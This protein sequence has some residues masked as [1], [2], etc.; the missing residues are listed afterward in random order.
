MFGRK[1]KESQEHT[2]SYP[3]VPAKEA[4]GKIAEYKE[5]IALG[6]E[7]IK[8]EMKAFEIAAENLKAASK[9]VSKVKGAFS[10][11]LSKRTAKKHGGDIDAYN[12]SLDAYI[13]ISS[14]I[15]WLLNTV[16]S[17]YEASA[18]L[19]EGMKRYSIARKLRIESKKYIADINCKKAKLEKVAD[20]IM[21]PLTSYVR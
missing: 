19:Y 14:H 3:S 17:C 13:R 8:T 16:S 5:S 9:K 10:S 18:R 6:K 1:S 4:K 2:R 7:S 12:E 20:G 15:N 11:N 21:M